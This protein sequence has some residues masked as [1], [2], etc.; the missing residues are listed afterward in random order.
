[1]ERTGPDQL[2]EPEIALRNLLAGGPRTSREVRDAMAIRQFSEK[3]TRTAREKQGV[4]IERAGSGLAMHSTWH[5]PGVTADAAALTA[6]NTRCT[7]S[8]GAAGLSNAV[9]VAPVDDALGDSTSLALD[10]SKPVVA[11]RV[12][13][14]AV[15]EAEAFVPLAGDTRAPTSDAVSTEHVSTRF[16]PD[17]RLP[18]APATRPVNS[19]G[20]H[21]QAAAAPVSACLEMSAATVIG[22]AVGALLDD[23]AGQG[24][25]VRSTPV[26]TR[27]RSGTAATVADASSPGQAPESA[28]SNAERNRHQARAEAFSSRG[29]AASDARKL[30]DAL[31]QRDRSGAP[32]TGSCIECQCVALQECPVA[33]RPAGEIHQCWYMRNVGP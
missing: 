5:L 26:R 2:T 3:Q 8:D 24:A 32:A 16:P 6:D 9:A 27:V 4:V 19:T 11:A 22:A 30:V 20:A 14:G 13:V 33:P 15:L 29:M 31:I 23:A 28:V 10:L 21:V 12:V 18:G 1:M 17:R 7:P 25:A